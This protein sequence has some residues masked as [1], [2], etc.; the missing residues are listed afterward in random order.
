MLF[1]AFRPPS[2]IHRVEVGDVGKETRKKSRE[3]VADIDMVHF[4]G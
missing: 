2:P 1:H 4:A 3:K